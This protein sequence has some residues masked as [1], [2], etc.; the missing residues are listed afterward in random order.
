[1][2]D[3]RVVLLNG[4]IIWA[5]EEP[6]LL[7]ALRGGGG[8]FGGTSVSSSQ[9][10]LPN[11]YKKF[12]PVVTTFKL[13]CY[14]YTSSVYAGFIMY[15]SRAVDE[16]SKRVAEFVKY[17]DPKMALHVLIGDMEG[18]AVRGEPPKPT[19]SLLVFDAHGE[20]HGRSDA[21]F[22]WALDIEGAID[23]TAGMSYQSVNQLQGN[24]EQKLSLETA[25]KS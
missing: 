17:P 4:K 9:F 24:V 22:K 3:A 6:D 20:D 18:Y 5:S 16:I 8:N 10:I 2:L 12:P 21:G 1:M 14:R 11:S 13:R 19:I 7:W 15:P 25:L 23:A